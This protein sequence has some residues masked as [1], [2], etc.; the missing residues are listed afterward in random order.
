MGV[1]HSKTDTQGLGTT[2][3]LG[4]CCAALGAALRPVNLAARFLQ[5]REARF[6]A[7]AAAPNG[8]CFPTE[9]ASFASKEAL[10][11]AVR[12]LA[13]L[14]GDA[15]AR[16]DSDGHVRQRFSEHCLQVTGAQYLRSLGL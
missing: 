8:P 1:R 16:V 12:W 2:S 11:A 6:P 15:L 5:A 14:L 4:C 9:A 3:T 10:I 7:L 13:P